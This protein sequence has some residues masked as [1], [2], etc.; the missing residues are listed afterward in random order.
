MDPQIA[1]LVASAITGVC[2]ISAA[3]V[4]AIINLKAQFK[5]EEYQR[6]K[7]RAGRLKKDLV[8]AYWQIAS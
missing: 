4:V 1:P 8:A 3:A 2:A 6:V 7:D 5:K